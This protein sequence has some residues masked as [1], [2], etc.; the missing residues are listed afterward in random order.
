LF[1]FF[2]LFIITTI[3]YIL[4]IQSIFSDNEIK[5]TSIKEITTQDNNKIDTVLEEK[6]NNN[7]N[8]TIPKVEK[9]EDK[10]EKEI[11]TFFDKANILVID[12]KYQKAI[13]IY[14][15][16]IEKL[17]NK[18]KISFIKSF[19]KAHFFKAYLYR[20]Y[21]D[22]NYEAIKDYNAI[23][24]RCKDSS[25]VELLK[26]Y[27]NAQ[28]LKAY[29]L[30]K[31]EAMDIY[32]EIIDKFRN[33][34]NV[35]LLKKFVSAQY[36]KTYIS[37][38]KEKLDI[39]DDII[40]RFKK[41]TNKELLK[42]LAYAQFSKARL[43]SEYFKNSS[44]AIDVYDEIISHFEQ[45]EDDESKQIVA[46]A[47]FDKSYA[48]MRDDG[49]ESMN[50]LDDLIDRYKNS[51]DKGL[52]KNIEYSIINNIELALVTNNDDRDYRELASKYLSD[53]A[54][55]K[56]QL[57]MLE[58]LKNAQDTDQDEELK[59]WEEENK[60]YI[61][62]NWSFEELKR[63]NRSMEDGEAKDRIKK[64]LDEFIKHDENS[65]INLYESNKSIAQQDIS[66][67]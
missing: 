32:D 13:N 8:I 65:I 20:N 12:G 24:E 39:Y 56:P 49:E 11:S 26:L 16:I 29:L 1:K 41:S 17:K 66:H 54:D 62:E 36:S 38:P 63:W 61:F 31:D 58:I 55:T 6:E 37:S 51:K 40:Q 10:L 60:D 5:E 44:D 46:D 15:M 21:L 2:L 45:F 27:Y 30:D 59:R 4:T 42:E 57:D 14:N 50:I 64:Y 28:T 3:I 18:D 23:I 48:L 19:T 35:E 43:L 7:Q 52:S 47:L 34:D 53:T 33:S 67:L 22:D 9:I 25:N